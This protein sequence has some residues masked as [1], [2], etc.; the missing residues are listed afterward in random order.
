MR[1]VYY[2]LILMWATTGILQ[3]QNP[4]LAKKYFEEAEFEKAIAEYKILADKFPYKSEYTINLLRSYQALQKYKEAEKLITQRKLKN[5]PQYWVYLGYNY[6]LQKD[7]IHAKKYYQK[8]IKATSKRSYYVYQVGE[9][10]KKFYLL[11]EALQV[12]QEAIQRGENKNFYMQIAQIY[13]EKN[14]MEQMISNYLNLYAVSDAY[15]NNVKYYLTRFITQD[16]ENKVND[17]L[18]NQLI[19]RVHDTKE[20]RWYRLLYWLYVQQKEYRKAFWQLKSLYRKSDAE[21]SEIYHLG[22]T[23]NYA[24]QYDAARSMYEFVAQNAKEEKYAQLAKLALLKRDTQAILDTEKKQEIEEIFKLYLSQNWDLRNCVQLQILYA[25]FLAFHLKKDDE[26]LDLL[27]SLSKYNLGKRQRADI[28]LKKADIL[29]YNEHFNQALILY[30]QVQLDFPNNPTGHKAT[31]KI[32]QASFFQGDIDW[33]HSQLK[34]IKSVSDDLIANDAIDLDLIII[35]NKEEGDSLQ[36]GLKKF[37]KAKFE[38]YRKNPGKAV[39]MLDS[40]KQKFKGQLIYDDAL[41]TQAQVWEQ[42]GN[43]DLA[44][45]N[46]QAI[47]DNKTEDL[48]K[49]D[50]LYRMAIIY[51]TQ[52]DDEDKAKALFKKIVLEYPASFWFVDARKHFRK[53]RGDEIEN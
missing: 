2:I 17:I 4:A 36:S 11:D 27:E 32:A 5:S 40:I 24:K 53:L 48:L 19:Q 9:A 39:A 26:A 37:A 10:F 31:Y 21:I 35:N 12:Y 50:A 33:A 16:P 34:V 14:D 13:A 42:Q 30:T 6:Q 22:N 47:L 23:A 46:Y 43:Y 29:M 51:E 49:D 44:L 7:T 20:T 38:I 41:W 8:A 52:L 45:Q 25:D 28:K 3:A 15:Q 18:K 1:K